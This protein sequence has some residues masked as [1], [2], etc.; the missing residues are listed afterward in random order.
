[1][2]AAPR[3]FRLSSAHIQNGLLAAE[4][5]LCNGRSRVGRRRLR[6]AR[7]ARLRGNA[8]VARGGARRRGAP[9]RGRRDAAQRRRVDGHPAHWP[10]RVLEHSAAA[11]G[12]RRATRDAAAPGPAASKRSHAPPAPCASPQIF[13]LADFLDT[14]LPRIRGKP[15]LR[16]CL[17]N[18]TP[19]ITVSLVSLPLSISLAIAAD[20]S[21]VQGV[22]TAVWAG[23]VSAVCGGSHYNIVGPTGALSGILS[24]Y[25]VTYG[26]AVQPLLAILSGMLSIL[27]WFSGIDAYLIFVPGAVRCARAPDAES[28]PMPACAR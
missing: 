23:L 10:R 14:K 19:G 5:L 11:R 15:A 12:A 24:Y 13:A 3:R 2:G 4:S 8:L 28:A 17:D 1:M 18:L 22:I 25:S 9:A 21:P 7:R 26:P 20:A 16:E 27:V 6:R